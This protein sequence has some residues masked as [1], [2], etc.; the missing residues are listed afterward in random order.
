MLKKDRAA[1]AGFFLLPIIIGLLLEFLPNSIEYKNLKGD[2]GAF[3]AFTPSILLG[4]YLIFSIIQNGV[5]FFT[6][7]DH[8]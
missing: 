5:K 6:R 1:V 2:L 8:E 3:I 7:K 4:V